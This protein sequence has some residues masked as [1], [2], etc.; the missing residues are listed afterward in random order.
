MSS[1]CKMEFYFKTADILKL[2]KEN[3]K[4]RGIIVSQE[5]I[6]KRGPKGKPANVVL[7]TARLAEEPVT[8]NTKLTQMVKAG[9]DEVYGCPY[10]PGCTE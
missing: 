5:I 8:A 1:H 3:K 6:P 7:I 10:P 9:G 2:L 4:A